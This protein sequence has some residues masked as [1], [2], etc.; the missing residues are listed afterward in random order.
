MKEVVTYTVLIVVISTFLAFEVYDQATEE[1]F[2]DDF[3]EHRAALRSF[4]EQHHAIAMCKE[5]HGM[6]KATTNEVLE[7][8]IYLTDQFG[9]SE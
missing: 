8:K 4:Y 6:E 2:F 7:C 3:D 1:K 5:I 9:R